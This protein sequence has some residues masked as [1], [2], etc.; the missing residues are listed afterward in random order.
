MRCPK[1]SWCSLLQENII[2]K[3]HL[4]FCT[5]QVK[6]S[7]PC[8]CL[9]VWDV[10]FLLFPLVPDCRRSLLGPGWRWALVAGAGRGA[11]GASGAV[12]VTRRGPECREREHCHQCAAKIY[13][14]TIC[15]HTQWWAVM[16]YSLPFLTH[17]MSA[18]SSGCEY[19]VVLTSCFISIS[20]NL[21]SCLHD[22][23][24]FHNKCYRVIFQHSIFGWRCILNS[25]PKPFTH[26]ISRLKWLNI[27]NIASP[28]QFWATPAQ[29]PLAIPID[30]RWFKFKTIT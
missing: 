8:L 17:T 22:V 16:Y 27:P 20:I 1:E 7:I 11:P 5:D 23:S 15:H 24:F 10:S 30:F 4:S 14:E 2:G 6:K 19:P 12:T 28:G 13:S 25:S 29:P 18:L 26:V 9:R 3:F 21:V